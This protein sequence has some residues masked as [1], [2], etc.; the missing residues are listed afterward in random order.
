MR[1]PSANYFALFFATK[2]IFTLHN[3][4]SFELI[5]NITVENHNRKS[6]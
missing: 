1:K 2:R 3:L 4:K 5:L 6:E